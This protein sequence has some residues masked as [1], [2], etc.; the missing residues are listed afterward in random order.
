MVLPCNTYPG[1]SLYQSQLRLDS[2][3]GQTSYTLSYEMLLLGQ[4]K[5]KRMN[6]CPSLLSKPTRPLDRL[7]LVSSYI[8]R[9]YHDRQRKR[10][11]FGL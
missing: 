5:N 3:L 10:I 6:T 11:A 2:Y 9:D 4:S 1:Y 7:L 8:A